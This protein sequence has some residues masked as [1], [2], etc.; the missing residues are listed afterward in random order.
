MD[1]GTAQR[2]D[3]VC[4]CGRNAAGFTLVELLVVVGI[5]SI[6]A[7]I[8]IQ[9]YH[10]YRVA[11]FDARAMHDIGNAAI[12]QEAHYANAHTYA[13]FAVTGPA[14]LTVPGLVV[15]DT[16]TLT[17]AA[18]TDGYTITSISSRGSGKLFTYDSET[19]TIRGD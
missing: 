8:A 17:S 13:S 6:L 3:R 9:Q 5:L 14:V 15:S 2:Q 1:N 16:V 19:D 12:A 11:A 7:A 10:L 4:H 18:N